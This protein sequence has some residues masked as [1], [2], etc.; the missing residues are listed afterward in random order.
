MSN[1][2]QTLTTLPAYIGLNG[3]PLTTNELRYREDLGYVYE[4]IYKYRGQQLLGGNIFPLYFRYSAVQCRYKFE[5][6]KKKT[7]KL[8]SDS[9]RG[10]TK[11]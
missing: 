9:T 1:G 10:N 5:F 2:Q 3:E 8:W 7:G 4:M 6:S 11:D